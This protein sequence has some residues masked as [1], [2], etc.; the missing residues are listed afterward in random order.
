MSPP[1]NPLVPAVVIGLGVNGLGTV[2]ALARRGV[3]TIAITNGSG[4]PPEHTRFGEKI[5]LPEISDPAALVECL[6]A[7]GKRLS[8]K[9]IVFPSGDL[10]L[11]YVSEHRADLEP[12]GCGWH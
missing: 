1:P 4:E 3:P 5:V 7:V 9:S 2:R 6:V 11:G 12:Y 8:G 10:S